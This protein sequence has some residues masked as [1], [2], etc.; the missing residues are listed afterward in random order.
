MQLSA[1]NALDEALLLL[2]VRLRQIVGKRSTGRKLR[3]TL[4]FATLPHPL[5]VAYNPERSAI[6]QLRGAARPE[7]ALAHLERPL[8]E[9]RRAEAE[10][11]VVRIAE[12]HVEMREAVVARCVTAV[13]VAAADGTHG[14]ILERPICDIE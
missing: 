11:H 4:P 10:M 3:R 14:M 2:R 13:A 12:N 7:K 1:G 8:P 6:W 5:L 9:L